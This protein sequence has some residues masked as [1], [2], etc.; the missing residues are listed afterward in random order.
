MP[1]RI[2]LMDGPA[3]WLESGQLMVVLVAGFFILTAATPWYWKAAVATLLFPYAFVLH[4]SAR[5]SK[6][7]RLLLRLDG[8]LRL[9]CSGGEVEGLLDGGAWVSRWISVLHWTDL[10]DGSRRHSLVCAAANRADD[11]RRLMVWLRMGVGDQ[12]AATSW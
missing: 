1:E 11:Y 3:R 2:E 5:R 7:N 4:R 8:S 9:F 6:R 10:E 12:K